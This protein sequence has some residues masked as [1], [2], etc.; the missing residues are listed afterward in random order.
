MPLELQLQLQIGAD[1]ESLW[2]T[3]KTGEYDAV[4]KPGGWGTPNPELDESAL[5]LYPVRMESPVKPLVITTGGSDPIRFNLSAANTDENVWQFDMDKGG[6]Y[7]TYI[8]QF[9]LSSDGINYLDT[10]VINTDDYYVLTTDNKLYKSGTGEITDFDTLIGE[11]GVPQ[12][13]CENLFYP[14]LT[15]LMQQKYRD[16]KTARDT[17]CGDVNAEFESYLQL[18]EDVDSSDYTFWSG[19]KNEAHNMIQTLLDDNGL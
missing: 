16:Y 12:T 10:S 1:G 14:G 8:F 5:L 13:L 9:G 15:V 2:G 3:D 7:R 11:S 4:S 19:L 17:D 18:K 6:Y